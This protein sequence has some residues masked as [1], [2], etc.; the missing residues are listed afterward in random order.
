[1]KK[2]TQT[3][4][5]LT[6]LRQN[7][8][9]SSLEVTIALRIV[10]VTGRVSDLRAAGH[11]IDCWTDKDGVARYTVKEPAPVTKGEAVPLWDVAS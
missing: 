11:V 7:P 8:G 1:M 4:R 5:L 3:E 10:N 9:S 2:P 6:W